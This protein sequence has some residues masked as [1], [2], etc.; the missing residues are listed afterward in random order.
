MRQREEVFAIN[1]LQG[2][3]RKASIYR[4]ESL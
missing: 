4:N 1:K 2:W 3:R